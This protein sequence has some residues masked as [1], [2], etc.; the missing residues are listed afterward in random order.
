M[1]TQK[2]M[3]S[4]NVK[5][6]TLVELIV[7]ITIL[8]I[9]GTIAFLNLGG[10]SGSARDSQ[11]TSDLTQIN[12][13]VMTIQAK[14]GVS[15]VNM[16]ADTVNSLTGANI[17]IG[18]TGVAT[19]AVGGTYVAGNANY[20][21]LGVDSTKMSDPTSAGTKRYRMGA[22]ILA[23]GVYEL[24]ATLEETTT[25]LVMGTYRPRNPVTTAMPTGTGSLTVLLGISDAGKFYNADIIT[26]NGTYT[27][28]ITS[29][30]TGTVVSLGTT[31]Q[32]AGTGQVSLA[33]AETKG[34]IGGTD[35][36]SPVINK[37]NVVPY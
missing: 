23:G 12:Q 2:T 24:A 29:L 7:V 19:P 3:T 1:N 16:V 11:R 22:T 26:A 17:S 18:G 13:Q 28:T 5:G 25:A 34:L 36:I 8:V 4:T 14:N 35:G 33:K 21:V 27:G 20:T 6:F 30:V 31:T 10:M 37:G 15:Y 9:L 32:V